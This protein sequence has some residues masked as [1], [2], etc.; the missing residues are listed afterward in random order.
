MEQVALKI[1]ARKVFKDHLALLGREVAVMHAM[2]QHD[3]LLPLRRVMYAK[4]R[5]YLVTGELCEASHNCMLS[6]DLA[7]TACTQST[8]ANLGKQ[9]MPALPDPANDRM[10]SRLFN[11][12][13][14]QHACTKLAQ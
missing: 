4:Q 2:G 8:R 13:L 5:L 12:G 6:C 11:P 14:M 3:H 7:L 10:C 1:M 9:T